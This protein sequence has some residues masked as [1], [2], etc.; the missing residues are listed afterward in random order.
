MNSTARFAKVIQSRSGAVGIVSDALTTPKPQG[1]ID[2]AITSRSSPVRAA[3]IYAG[4]E[5]AQG[6]E[7][8]GLVA[9]TQSGWV[10]MGAVA[11]ERPRDGVRLSRPAPATGRSCF[12]GIDCGEQLLHGARRRCAERLVEMDRLGKLL[13]DE[14]VAPCEFT[15]TRERLLD[16]MGVAAA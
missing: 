13:A 14:L 7:L 11:R 6:I 15:I 9:A 3:A 5:I 16:A 8:K 2:R 1:I 10:L 12:L 4:G